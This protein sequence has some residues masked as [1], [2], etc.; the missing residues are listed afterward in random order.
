MATRTLDLP[1]MRLDRR[2][3]NPWHMAIFIVVTV[4]VV[5]P[6]G[7]LILGSFS[8]AKMPMDFTWSTLTFDNYPEVW[9]DPGSYN[10]L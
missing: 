1:T 4:L 5:V 2:K 7:V 3:L 6:V 8:N 10:I 9:L